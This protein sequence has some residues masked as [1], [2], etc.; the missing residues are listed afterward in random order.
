MESRFILYSTNALQVY[1][2][3]DTKRPHLAYDDY[4]LPSSIRE[5]FDF[6]T[7]TI[8]FDAIVPQPK[9]KRQ[10]VGDALTSTLVNIDPMAPGSPNNPSHVKL[11]PIIAG[12]GVTPNVNAFTL[13]NGNLYVTP[14][15]LRALYDFR[16][17][18]SLRKCPFHSYS[19]VLIESDHRLAFSSTHLKNPPIRSQLLLFAF[20]R[21][22]P[23][24]N[25]ANNKTHRR[26]YNSDDCRNL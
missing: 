23:M 14:V 24:R 20:C 3:S 9:K 4:S 6:I 1:E 18:L 15:C 7:P 12:S 11:G 25:W 2:H 16:L 26:S 10:V 8:H 17:G 13:S 5:H 21:E 22:Y 19:S